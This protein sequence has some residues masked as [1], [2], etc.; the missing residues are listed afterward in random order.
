MNFATH[1]LTAY[2]PTST[3][4]R[5]N[6][7]CDCRQAI[8]NFYQ[9]LAKGKEPTNNEG[10][11]NRQDLGKEIVPSNSDKKPVIFINNLFFKETTVSV[12]SVNQALIFS[13]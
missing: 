4:N 1:T 5:F 10:Q 13:F 12:S 7:F 9:C 11:K 2:S 3:L 8:G 6:R